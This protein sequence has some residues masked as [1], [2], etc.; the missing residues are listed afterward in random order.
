MSDKG[1]QRE[2]QKKN[3]INSL[4]QVMAQDGQHQIAAEINTARTFSIVSGQNTR[5]FMFN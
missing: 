4:I 5:Y 2:K 1:R 3:F